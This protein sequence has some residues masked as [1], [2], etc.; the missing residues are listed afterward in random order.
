MGSILENSTSLAESYQSPEPR[1]KLL[2][3]AL[4][5][6][7]VGEVL[8][9]IWAIGYAFVGV[10]FST[11]DMGLNVYT[12]V[13]LLFSLLSAGLYL[14]TVVLFLMWFHRVYKNLTPL[15]AT[16]LQYSPG[17]TIGAWFIPIGNLFIPYRITKEIWVKSGERHDDYA[18]LNTESTVPS[19]IGTWWGFW[20]V[21]NISIN[22]SNR[23]DPSASGIEGLPML[24]LM[25]V[26]ASILAAV[27]AIRMIKMITAR[28]E[29]NIAQ[30]TNY[31][32]PPVYES[33]GAEACTQ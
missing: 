12:G 7:I 4:S 18:F 31:G 26:A 30:M 29:E 5:T 27:Y 19:V 13:I 22:I 20:I 28:Q 24:T 14:S 6:Y 11:D 25:S 17:W 8:S 2:V 9:G 32:P 16:G 15:G 23:M 21:S 33:F 3:G 1:A 10:G